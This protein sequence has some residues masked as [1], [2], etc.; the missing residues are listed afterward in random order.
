MKEFSNDISVTNQHNFSHL[1]FQRMLCYLRRDI[2]EHILKNDESDYFDIDIWCRNRLKNDTET[3]KKMIDVI[4]NE[5]SQKGWTCKITFG[6]S[7][8]FIFAK[9]PPVNYFEDGL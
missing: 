9:N 8:L 3:M 2:Y 5:L 4:V 6:S 1:F 7:A